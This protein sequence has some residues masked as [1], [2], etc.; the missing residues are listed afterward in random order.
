VHEC[1][2]IEIH[3]AIWIIPAGTKNFK[4]PQAMNIFEIGGCENQQFRKTLFNTLPFSFGFIFIFSW[5]V[6]FIVVHASVSIAPC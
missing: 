1:V 5:R 3:V 4:P 6:A 2:E